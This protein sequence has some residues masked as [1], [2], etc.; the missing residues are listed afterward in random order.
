[1]SFR[2]F[3]ESAA[4]SGNLVRISKQVSK[5]LE[6]SAILVELGDKSVLFEKVKDNDFRIAGNLCISKEAFANY[7]GIKPNELVPKMMNA[8]SNPKKPE[9]VKD[10]PCQEVEMPEVDLDKLPILF[11]CSKDGGNY[12]SSGV[13]VIKKSNGVQNLDFHRAMQIGKN[14]FTIRVVPSRDFDN[15]LKEGGGTIDA[16]MCVGCSPNVLLGAATSVSAD[17]DEVEIANALEPL[18]LVKAKTT[19]LMIPADTEFVLEGRILAE[20]ADEGPFV[21][22]TETYDIVRQEPI[23]EVTK[24]TH[25]K[26][27]LWHAL[28]PGKL[29]HRILMGMPREPTIFKHVN[30]AGVKSLDVSVNPGGCSWLHGIVQIEKKHDDDGKKAIQAAFQG[31]KS[32]KHVFIVDHDI[33]INDPL[34]VEWAMSTRFQ[35]NKDMV[36]KEGEKGSSLDPSANPMTK[37]TT[38]VGF[39]LTAP[40][41]K[42]RKNFEKAE[43]PKVDIDKF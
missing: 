32:M 4:K 16:V 26:D 15:A 24:I 28:L 8:M 23:F 22:L 12:V 6:V 40:I 35:G 2:E 14:R 9:I 10:A 25:R 11:H 33:D 27:P 19:D 1:M 17:Q 43:F 37:E 21:D 34:Q 18:K 29:E 41:G 39:D 5:K 36:I 7:F 31:H 42:E 13:F 20:K 38:K 30:D 3:V